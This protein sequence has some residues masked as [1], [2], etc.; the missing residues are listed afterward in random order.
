MLHNTVCKS[1]FSNVNEFIVM[2]HRKVGYRLIALQCTI[3][4]SYYSFILLAYCIS[5][6]AAH[7]RGFFF[8]SS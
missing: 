4:D 8:V 3:G 5:I 7:L 6:I 2:R 1:F